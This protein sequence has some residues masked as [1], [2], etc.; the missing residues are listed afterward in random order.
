[1]KNISL[2]N[3][4]FIIKIDIFNPVIEKFNNKL[5]QILKMI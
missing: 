5:C 2:K 3:Y 4:S 1:M